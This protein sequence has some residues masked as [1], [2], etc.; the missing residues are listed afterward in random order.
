[1]PRTARTAFK[2]NACDCEMDDPGTKKNTAS[3]RK[4]SYDEKS[5]NSIWRALACN[6]EMCRAF[7]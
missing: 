5:M 2:G 4:E 6:R 1:M 7:R 3:S